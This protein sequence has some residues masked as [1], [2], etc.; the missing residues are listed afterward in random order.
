MQWSGCVQI[1]SWPVH[2]LHANHRHLLSRGV[3]LVIKNKIQIKK[4]WAFNDHTSCIPGDRIRATVLAFLSLV[5]AIALHGLSAFS[6]SVARSPW[7]VGRRSRMSQET[8]TKKFI[9]HIRDVSSKS[10][11][12]SLQQAHRVARQCLNPWPH[13]TTH[14][15][16]SGRKKKSLKNTS[17]R[18]FYWYVLQW[19][20]D[21]LH[22]Y[23]VWL[24]WWV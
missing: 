9:S 17:W 10:L 23:K 8:T 4:H 12:W 21:A 6:L 1:T 15:W 2:D 11:H 14:T 5:F 24:T 16:W 3:T 22:D 7:S 19:L 20:W 13:W 18:I